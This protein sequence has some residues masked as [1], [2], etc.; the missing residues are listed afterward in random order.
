ME[1]INTTTKFIALFLAFFIILK[2]NIVESLL[3]KTIIEKNIINKSRIIKN[4]PENNNTF[5]NKCLEYMKKKE[6]E[7]KGIIPRSLE[8]LLEKKDE[9]YNLFQNLNLNIDIFCSFYEIFNDQIYDL[10]N[11]SSW[12]NYNPSIFKEKPL[13]GVLKEN[14][15]K[16][17]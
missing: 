15:K 10:F 7:G 13:E 3:D 6:E 9:L 16:I 12:I 5:Q 2:A 11:N 4:N 14:L 17:K 8:Y 1:Y